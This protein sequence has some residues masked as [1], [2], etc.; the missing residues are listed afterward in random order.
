MLETVITRCA[1]ALINVEVYEGIFYFNF[2]H[3]TVL[4]VV[5]I[6]E[7]INFLVH[8]TTICLEK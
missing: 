5:E 7:G 8:N 2:F 4:P 6:S 3:S 1:D